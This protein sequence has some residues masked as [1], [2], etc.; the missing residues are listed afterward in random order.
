MDETLRIYPAAVG[1]VPRIIQRNGETIGGH[2][3][4]GGVSFAL[5]KLPTKIL[6]GAAILM[7]VVHLRQS[8][9]S[10]IGLCITTQP[11]LSSRRS[12][13]RNVGWGILAFQETKK[14]HLN[15]SQ[16]ASGTA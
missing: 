9:T 6:P 4:P 10:G 7:C 11:I 14:P 13:L 2:F 15:R 1:S 16:L 5:G 12:S 8:W 3:L